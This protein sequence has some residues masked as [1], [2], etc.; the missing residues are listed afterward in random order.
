M[1]KA[2]DSDPSLW[3]QFPEILAWVSIC[4]G[5]PTR[6]LYGNSSISSEQGVHQGDPLAALVFP[7]ALQPIIDIIEERVPGL[8]V[9]AWYLDDGT[10]VGTLDH[11]QEVVDIL[12]AEGPAEGL[13]PV[14]RRHGRC[15]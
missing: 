2:L 7:L 15:W 8:K 4:Y 1:R 5:Q 11:L 6:L 13:D 10:L 12:L 9:D 3:W 14:H